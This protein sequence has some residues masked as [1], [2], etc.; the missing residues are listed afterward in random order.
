MLKL[1]GDHLAG[2]DSDILKHRP[3]AILNR[4]GLEAAGQ[5]LFWARPS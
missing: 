2:G 5:L 1:L 4:R 3:S